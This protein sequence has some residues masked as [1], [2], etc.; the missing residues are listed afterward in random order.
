MKKVAFIPARYRST[1]FEGKPLALIAGRPMIQHVYERATKSQA[2]DEVY[3]ATD[4][5]GIFDCVVG[6]GGKAIMTDEHHQSGTDRIA[7]AADTLKLADHDIVVNIQGDQPIFQPT[8]ITEL[9][10]PLIEDP[11]L[12]MSTLMHRIKDDRELHDTNHIKVVVDNKGYALYFSRLTIP[13]Y[14]DRQPRVTHF[15][16]LGI[17]AYRKHFLV[18][19][20]KLGYGLLEEAEKLEQLRALEHGFKIRVVETPFDSTEV[21]TPDDIQVIEE[22]L[23]T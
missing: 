11:N 3:V 23:A 16:H 10:A 5:Q 15:K 1:R 12:P 20:T 19:F 7:E 21:D 14:R 9:I 8:I 18:T 4:D 6:F 13:F 2:L 22:K 17:Y